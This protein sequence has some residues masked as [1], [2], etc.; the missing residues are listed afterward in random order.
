MRIVVIDKETQKSTLHNID[1][2]K[3]ELGSRD[4]GKYKIFMLRNLETGKMHE[5]RVNKERYDTIIERPRSPSPKFRES[6]RRSFADD[7]DNDD[8]KEETSS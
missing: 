8:G 7:E 2:S 1:E 4:E 6:N 5:M 3:N